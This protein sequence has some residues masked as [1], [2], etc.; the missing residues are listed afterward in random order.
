VLW[1]ILD[2]QK[3]DVDAPQHLLPSQLVG[4][5]WEWE[6]IEQLLRYAA[7]GPVPPN[8]PV[9]AQRLFFCFLA[10]FTK[11]SHKCVFWKDLKNRP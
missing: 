6:V 8:L 3:P 9:P 5:D 10:P 4:W 7:I 11:D 2:A 1:V